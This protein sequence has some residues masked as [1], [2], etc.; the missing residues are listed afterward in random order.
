MDAKEQAREIWDKVNAW[1]TAKIG[2]LSF[3]EQLA[4][5]TEPGKK[6][7][8]LDEELS[9]AEALISSA[10]S[11]QAAEVERLTNGINAIVADWESQD[12]M[13]DAPNYSIH[14]IARTL[15]A[16]HV[17]RVKALLQPASPEPTP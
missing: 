5:A 16:K 1:G 9:Y 14:G 17:S 4:I 3:V 11:A 2:E 10:L 12:P 6:A 7:A 13:P 8:L 15:R